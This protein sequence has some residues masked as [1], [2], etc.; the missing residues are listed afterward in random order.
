MSL[1]HICGLPLCVA[2]LYAVYRFTWNKFTC[3]CLFLAR[4]SVVAEVSAIGASPSVL[5]GLRYDP[6][7]LASLLVPQGYSGNPMP[8]SGCAS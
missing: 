1:T 2:L 5:R 3:L 6:V 4:R 8:R 7:S